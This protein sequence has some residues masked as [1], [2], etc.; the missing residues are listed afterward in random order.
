[1]KNKLSP[2][3][4]LL[5]KSIAEIQGR[6]TMP[7]NTPTPGPHT[8]EPWQCNEKAPWKLSYPYVI[9]AAGQVVCRVSPIEE[10]TPRDVAKGHLLAAVP[11]LLAACEQACKLESEIDK[12]SWYASA[13]CPHIFRQI[14]DAIAKARGGTNG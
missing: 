3:A 6:K 5:A 4:F 13:F 14:K 1:M 12:E 11:E 8:P 2:L 10:E 9:D 7:E